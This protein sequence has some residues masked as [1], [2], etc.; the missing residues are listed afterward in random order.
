MHYIHKLSSRTIERIVGIFVLICFTATVALVLGI[1]VNKKMFAKEYQLVTKFKS[2]Y[3]IKPGTKIKLAGIEIGQVNWVGFNAAN[4]IEVRMN[5]ENRF[6]EK[7]RA[8]SIVTVGGAGIGGDKVLN[9]SIGAPKQMV[10]V[11]N[12]RIL[13]EEPVELGD[14]TAKV[15]SAIGQVETIMKNVVQ[16]AK[17]VN[18]AS[19]K[20]NLVLGNANSLVTNVD[21]IAGDIQKG[22]GS[23]GMLIEKDKLYKDLERSVEN[24]EK[25]T[26]N[27]KKG[28][29]DVPS[30]M[31]RVRSIL[32]ET[33]KVVLGLQRHWLINGGVKKAEKELKNKEKSKY[34][35]TSLTISTVA[36]TAIVP[37]KKK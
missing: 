31:M 22:K 3:G 35:S 27:V 32:D 8:D 29:D 2:G 33:N 12:S 37:V 30:L 17:N 19:E 25:I 5:I 34:E 28:T 18:T 11:N 7:I 13:S 23:I 9:I 1:A 20:L 6:Q 16:V 14:I 36:V 24:V 21:A 10:L 4:F 15:N 26:L